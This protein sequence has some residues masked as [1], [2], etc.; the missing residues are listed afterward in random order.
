[1]IAT[2]TRTLPIS[3]RCQVWTCDRCG[4][5]AVPEPTAFNSMRGG[6]TGPALD[7]T[8]HQG[9]PEGWR[10]VRTVADEQ[11]LCP[12]CCR[13]LDTFMQPPTAPSDRRQSKEPKAA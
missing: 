5:E 4:D 3:V 2:D 7:G 10:K 1:M 11:V 12:K 13:A 8:A 9:T 6:T